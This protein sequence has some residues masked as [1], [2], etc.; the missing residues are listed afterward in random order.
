MPKDVL[1]DCGPM[2]FMIFPKVTVRKLLIRYLIW[3]PY[4]AITRLLR[5]VY[6][7]LFL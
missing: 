4:R 2:I 3:I 5:S 6:D 1:Y 7:V